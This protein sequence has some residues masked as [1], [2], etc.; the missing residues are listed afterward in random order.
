LIIDELASP[1]PAPDMTRAIMG[2]LGYMRLPEQTVRKRRRNKFMRR[3]ATA[4]CLGVALGVG[5]LAHMQSADSRLPTGPTIPA[6]LHESINFGGTQID[7]ALDS[8]R[9]L[10][11]VFPGSGGGSNDHEKPSALPDPLRHIRP[12]L[13]RENHPPFRWV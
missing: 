8:F 9:R 4:A 13:Q 6:A 5:L 1:V 2:R 11:H 10:D 3:L 7:R 12:E